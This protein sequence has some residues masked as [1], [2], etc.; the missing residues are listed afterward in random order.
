[1][2]RYLSILAAVPPGGLAEPFLY[3]DAKHI[4]H[5]WNGAPQNWESLNP[6]QPLRCS[7]HKSAL[8]VNLGIE[9]TSTTTLP[10]T[11][12]LIGPI[13]PVQYRVTYTRRQ[14]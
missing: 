9:S 12:V 1:V 10:L 3:Q 11:R 2:R 8:I 14:Q 4:M 13:S 6:N 5:S 7:Q